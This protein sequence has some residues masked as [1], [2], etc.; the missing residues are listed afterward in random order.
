[1]KALTV[2]Q[3]WAALIMRGAKTEEYRSRPTGHRGLLAIHSSRTPATWADHEAAAA[4]VGGGVT[5]EDVQRW[6]AEQPRGHVLGVVEVVGCRELE[7][8]EP[9][10]RWGRWAWLLARP[11]ALAEPARAVGQLGLWEWTPTPAKRRRDQQR[12]LFA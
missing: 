5:A 2:R 11:V 4:L 9:G 1:M 8:D 3:P 12:E 10:R 7:D 6:C